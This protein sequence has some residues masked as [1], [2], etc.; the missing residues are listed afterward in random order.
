[1]K[2]F[3]RKA[4]NSICHF[5]PTNQSQSFINMSKPKFRNVAHCIDS[6]PDDERVVTEY[7]R[8]LIVDLV[9]NCTEKLSYNVPFYSVNKTICFLWPGSVIWGQKR[10]YDGVRMGFTKGHLIQNDTQYF[11]Q[12]DRK[13]VT[14]RDFKTIAD[15][16][17]DVVK[18][19]L[20]DAI[21]IDKQLSVKTPK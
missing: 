7:L 3:H 14:M 11:V 16:D 17:V 15:I 20:F 9:P 13:Y 18:L 5:T 6:L 2:V 21:E 12:G 8:Q 4:A 10:M 1:L 19:Y